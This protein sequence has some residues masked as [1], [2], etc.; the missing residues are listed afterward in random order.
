MQTNVYPEDYL[1]EDYVNDSDDYVK[2][3]ATNRKRDLYLKIGM[4]TVYVLLL[5]VSIMVV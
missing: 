5:V 2:D 3:L 4:G 1:K